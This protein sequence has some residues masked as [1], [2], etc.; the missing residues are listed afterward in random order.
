MALY[1]TNFAEGST[2]SINDNKKLDT[3]QCVCA[4]NLGTINFGA[5]G[6]LEVTEPAQDI[7][8]SAK[9]IAGGEIVATGNVYVPAETAGT[10]ITA[11][12]T[13][14]RFHTTAV[15]TAPAGGSDIE[16]WC[17]RMLHHYT[18]SMTDTEDFIL[19]TKSG[20][21][22]LDAGVV[23]TAPNI[24]VSAH[25]IT[26]GAGAGFT[27]AGNANLPPLLSI[28]GCTLTVTGTTKHHD[29]NPGTYCGA[30]AAGAETDWCADMTAPVT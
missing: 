5:T 19:L 11:G 9:K 27:T 10:T 12:G 2:V 30:P 25:Q 18:A 15:C 1:N 14:E 26:C 16:G 7:F 21:I 4:G 22:T 17:N 13:V 23:I 24:F 3:S 6:R 28:T 8:V 29:G 20:K